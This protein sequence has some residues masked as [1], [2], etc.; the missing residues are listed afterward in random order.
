[1]DSEY[2]SILQ[3]K[4]AGLKDEKN[5]KSDE[6]KRL[7]SEI[8]VLQNSAENI[9]ELLR[10]EGVDVDRDDLKGLI[11]QPISDLAHDYLKSINSKKPMHYTDIFNGVLSSGKSIPGKNPAA[12]LLTHMSRDERFVRI[13]SGTYGLK[14]WGIQVPKIHKR[15][16]RKHKSNKRITNG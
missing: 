13:S 10:V 6:I 8:D 14:E 5:R 4:L 9:V 2:V 1:M 16:K 11:Q 15:K 3:K 12:N 7:L